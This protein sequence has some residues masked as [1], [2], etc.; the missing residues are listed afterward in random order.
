MLPEAAQSH[1]PDKTLG[2]LRVMS[3]LMQ[4]VMLVLHESYI[5]IGRD[6]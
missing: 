5:L 4:W 3:L 6:A 1:L 2:V